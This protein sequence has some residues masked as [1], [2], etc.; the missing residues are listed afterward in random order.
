[1]LAH[2][3]HGNDSGWDNATVFDAGRLAVT[4]DLAAFLILQMS[5]LGDLAMELELAEEAAEWHRAAAE[6]REALQQELWD[7][8]HFVA[9]AVDG[10][11]PRATASL[12]H[13]LPVVLGAELPP[14]P[15]AE[16]SEQI[17]A[18]LTPH[19]LATERVDSPHY[20]PDGYWRGPIWAPSTVLVED[21]LRR[22]GHIALADEISARF[23]ALCERSGFAEN[24]D[25]L[26][27]EGLRDRAYTWTASAY[28]L[29]AEAAALRSRTRG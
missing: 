28:L 18:H 17:A 11:G 8:R 9:R 15:S 10:G 14:G 6:M 29:F 4:P 2:Y 22:A 26:T 21:G 27:G 25:A 16:L 12:L 7:G 24:F 5:E 3:Q 20:Q 13:L 1:M 19:G 23:R